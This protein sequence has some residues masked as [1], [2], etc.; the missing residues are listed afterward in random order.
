MEKKNYK[1]TL[2]T[3]YIGS[4]TQAIL[5]NFTPLLFMRFHNEFGIPL[6]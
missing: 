6:G 4:I 2:V 1:R 5:A 3:C